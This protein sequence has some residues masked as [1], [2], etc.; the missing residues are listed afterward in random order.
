MDRCLHC[1]KDISM[2]VEFGNSNIHAEGMD[3]DGFTCS[4]NCHIKYHQHIEEE[5][6]A[7][8]K[9]FDGEFEKYMNGGKC[10]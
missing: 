9:M 8:S 3:F 1:K 7:I 2:D 5:M 4:K 10:L 6:G